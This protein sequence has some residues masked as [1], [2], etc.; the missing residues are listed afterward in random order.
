MKKPI[1]LF[2]QRHRFAAAACALLASTSAF[3]TDHFPNASHTRCAGTTD[4]GTTTPTPADP[5]PLMAAGWGPELGA[6]FMV[7]RW[8]EDWSG[9]DAAGVGTPL[10]TILLGNRS[11]LTLSTE[12]RIRYVAARNV[13]LQPSYDLAQGQLRAILGADLHVSPYLRVYGELGSGQVNDDRD[14]ATANFQNAMSLQQ[15][16]V[17]VRGHTGRFLVGVMAGR[18][19]FTD[20]PRQ[21]ISLS[22]GPNLHRTWNG[23]RLYAHGSRY[24]FGAF[25]FRATRLGRNGFDEG[26]S[27]GERLR[28]VNASFIVTP[29]EGPNTYLDP[30]WIHSDTPLLRLGGIA[31]LDNRDTVGTRLWGRRGKLRFDWTFARQSGDSVNKRRIDAWGLFAVQSL[32]L[33]E[34]GWKPRLTSHLDMATGGG[35]YATGEI[36]D[37]NPLYASSN[38]LGESQF[39]GLT[40]LLLFAP[41]ISITPSARTTLSLEYGYA[42]RMDTSDAAY[43]AGMRPYAG[44]E[45]VSG[46]HIGNLSRLNVAW[47]PRASVSVNFNLEYLDPGRVL[48]SAHLPSGAHA[49]LG[50]TYRY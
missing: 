33:S 38:Y 48:K 1:V 27:H 7:S 36:R 20:G 13:R 39:L 44:T 47:A 24:R 46:R 15:L 21:L 40:N 43:G 45:H 50:A 22:D 18:Q 10:K 14:I 11:S 16:F 12:A 9:M 6:G 23:V 5:Y 25:D 31:G 2:L 34:S 8:A 35:A 37:F 28:G 19:E 49:Y 29:G 3:A 32:A 26:T 4:A 42:R 30:F 17:D 41:G